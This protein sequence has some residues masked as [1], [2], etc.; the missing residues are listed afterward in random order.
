MTEVQKCN[1]KRNYPEIQ[2]KFFDFTRYSD[3][4]NLKINSGLYAWK[5][6]II[7]EECNIPNDDDFTFWPD[8]GCVL[9][10]PLILV[11]AALYFYGFYSIQ[12]GVLIKDFTHKET[13]DLVG[14]NKTGNLNMLSGGS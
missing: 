2:L 4:Y 11:R 14:L 10:K 13:I 3:Y 6:Q 12:S 1:F 8:A 5:P 9:R 7:H